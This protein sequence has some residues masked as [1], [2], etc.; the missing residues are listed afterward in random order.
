MSK[1]SIVLILLALAVAVAL[2]LVFVH[3][4]WVPWILEKIAFVLFGIAVFSYFLS[5]FAAI[6]S[7]KTA[8]VLVMIGYTIISY[9]LWVGFPVLVIYGIS[10]LF[11]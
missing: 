10:R 6:F 2:L 8:Q 7:E 1:K 3:V 11:V 5:W 4:P 9:G